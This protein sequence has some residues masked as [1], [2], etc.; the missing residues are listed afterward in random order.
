MG[1]LWK[2]YLEYIIKAMIEDDSEQV[3]K[4]CIKCLP[5]DDV[6][7]SYFTTKTLD[8]SDQV[9]KEAYISLKKQWTAFSLKYTGKI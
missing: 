7:L 6:T 8:V 2:F 4:E 3:R 9:R 1:S 5:L